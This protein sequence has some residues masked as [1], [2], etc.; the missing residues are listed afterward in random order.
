MMKIL[1]IL[2]WG[3]GTQPTALMLKMLKGE[4]YD[5]N[6]IPYKLDYIIFADTKGEHMLVYKQ[7]YK[8]IDYVKENYGI[9]VII[10]KKN[11]KEVS[12]SKA[13][14]MIEK[15][16]IEKYRSSEYADL[17]QSFLLYFSG[18]IKSADVMPFWTRNKYTGKVG[19]TPF[20]ACTFEYKINQMLKEIRKR[21]NVKSFDKKKLHLNMFIGYSY[22][23]LSR[24]KP[25][26]KSYAT[27]YAPLLDIYWTKSQ[28][29][30][31]V[32]N[33][34]GFVPKSSVCTF[35]FAN[36]FEMVYTVYKQDVKS[37]NKLI[38]LDNV[39][40]D[41]PNTHQLQ[42]DIFMFKFQADNN[43]RLQDLDMEQWYEN[44][45]HEKETGQMSIFDLESEW[46]CNEGCFL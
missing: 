25:N 31:Y 45:L 3:G 13:L 7:I 2:S 38:I 44:Y 39:M 16:E 32:K 4:I 42:D 33:E 21:E 19:K 41:K 15:K 18:K 8:V 9:D 34:L 14:E 6:K 36:D 12:Y 43:V 10:T 37:W 30:N 20:K 24:F 26:P 23:E 28:C 17:Y 1:N 22:D 27:N 46:G 40:K 35:C 5:E 11:K 29:M